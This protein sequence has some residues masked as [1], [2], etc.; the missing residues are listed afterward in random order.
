[1]PVPNVIGDLSTS[2]GANSPLGSE[3]PIL[4]DDYLRA[5]SAI[6]KQEHNNLGTASTAAVGAGL[7]G[8]LTATTYA[9][10]TVGAA[11]NSLVSFGTSLAASGGSALVGFIQTGTGASARTVDE[12]LLDLPV[13]V[14]DFG[15]DPTGVADST[16]AFTAA[17]TAHTQL[18][19]PP[20]TYKLNGFAL[21]CV[22]R[23]AGDLHTTITQG[24]NGTSAITVTS[25]TATGNLSAFEASGFT[26]HGSASPTVPAFQVTCSGSGALWRCRF[27]FTAKLTYQA[28]NVASSGTNFFDNDVTIRS[29]DTITTAVYQ[30][31]G[32]YNRYK[33]FLTNC[34]N[35]IALDHGGVNDKIWIVSDGQIKDSG[36]GTIFEQATVE[37]LYGTS[38]SAGE[39][40]IQL[41]GT[42]QT[43]RNPSVILP[44]TT[45]TKTTYAFKPGNGTI[46]DNPYIT[47]VGGTA[48][49]NPFDTNGGFLWTL[50]NGKSDCT[51]KLETIYD[52]SDNSHSL[53]YVT[54]EGDVSQYTAKG[55]TQGG[56]VIQRSSPSAPFSLNIL[57]SADA[58]ILTPSGTIATGQL[59]IIYG[60]VD[61]RVFNLRTTQTITT[62]SFVSTA[63]VTDLPVTLAAGGK[64]TFIYDSTAN[65]FY[66][67]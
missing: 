31:S 8:F 17:Q 44:G 30:Q 6:I 39:S 57:G 56:K 45:S 21:A 28:F 46:F 29:E 32:T 16:A 23:G 4:G 64:I 67:I 36:L 66:L 7:V 61:G 22:L 65:K 59:N 52:D 55:A 54:L 37:S 48:L 43:L 20:G 2:A 58:I 53:R 63:D 13:S 19:M 11:L 49:A 62:L 42:A 51:N 18:Y 50:R 34:A 1:M 3:S 14:V 40:V 9:T 10:A 60:L 47:V 5:L 25:S 26:L 35:S 27:D 12:R 15:A 24:T 38:L 33:L 41:T